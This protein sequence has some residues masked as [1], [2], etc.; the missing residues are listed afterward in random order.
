MSYKITY[1]ELNNP[2]KPPITVVDQSLDTSTSLTF[3]GKNYSG[4]GKVIAEDFLHLLENFASPASQQ[5][6]NPVQGQL[7]YDNT[8]SLLKVYDGGNWN[9]AGAIKKSNSAPTGGVSGDIWVN[10][11]TSQLYV[12]SGSNWI[13]VGP[14]FSAGS[15]TGPVAE[16][17]VDTVNVSHFVVTMYANNARVA[18]ISQESFVPKLALAGFTAINK[19]INLFVNPSSVD[20][21]NQQ[22][23]G[24]W[25]TASSANGLLVNNTVVAS[26]NFL[27]SDVVSTSNNQINIQNNSGLRIG[28]DLS[29]QIKTTGNSSQLVSTSSNNSVS[30]ILTDSGN[31]S[32]TVL[33][34]NANG[35]VGINNPSPVA[36]L[37]II[38]SAKTTGSVTVGTTLGV[39]GNAT[40]GGTSTLRDD[41]T[42]NGQLYLNWLNGS[43]PQPGPAMLPSTTLTYDLGSSDKKF[44]N[45]YAQNF[46]GNFSGTFAG[47]VTGAVDGSATQLANPTLFQLKGDVT[48]PN[49]SFNGASPDGTAQ[50]QTTIGT[51]FITSKPVADDSTTLNSVFPDTLVVYQQSSQRLVQMSKQTFFSHVPLVPIGSMMPF[52]GP[53]T[54]IP[55]GYLLCDGAEVLQNV[56]T[57]LYKV[58]GYIYSNGTP[59]GLKGNNTFKLPDL[60][61]R[62]P[63]GADNMN[64]NISVPD[65]RNP[66]LSI[67]TVGTAANRV[68]ETSADNIGAGSDSTSGPGT[69]KVTLTTSQLPQHTHTLKSGKNIQYYAVGDNA[70]AP[71]GDQTVIGHGLQGTT[72]TTRGL[73]NAGTVIEPT[74]GATVTGQSV[75]IMNPYLTINYIIYTG[76]NV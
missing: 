64:N 28:S 53:A 39:A 68:I 55:P 72:G 50:F 54:A 16:E 22:S 65:G 70:S 9:P 34:L 10:T 37:D 61:G 36:E 2:N 13:L 29:F 45:I 76:V 38:G 40:V 66:N 6:I 30:V 25:G 52:A 4:Y 7:W 31:N 5:P 18:I 41:V 33:Q 67:T 74:S 56:Y 19:G 32:N 75:N 57:A 71:D 24:M 63:L 3:V 44:R 12:F 62:F 14:Q 73:T 8:N 21:A 20:P 60:R 11:A 23:A 48:A 47:Y 1:T 69:S 59:S 43:T 26:A 17:L 51:Q 42:I 27:R 58:I 15:A 46:V 49:V 35:K